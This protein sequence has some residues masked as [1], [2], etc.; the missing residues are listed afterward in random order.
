M[1]RSR[2]EPFGSDLATFVIPRS[3][4]GTWETVE[5]SRKIFV[6]IDTPGRRG[7]S[8]LDPGL[9][10]VVGTDVVV[11]DLEHVLVR[12]VVLRVGPDRDD[13]V[14][15]VDQLERLEVRLRIVS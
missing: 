13:H 11:V 3:F 4:S 14:L 7:T 9:Q 12:V 5:T 6:A 2:P 8:P 10:H 15:G 1:C